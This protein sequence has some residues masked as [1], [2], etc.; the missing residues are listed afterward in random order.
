M[1]KLLSI[2]AA[3]LLTVSLLTVP[4]SAACRGKALAGSLLKQALQNRICG[5]EI[6]NIN[7]S[8]VCPGLDWLFKPN[9]NQH[10]TNQPNVNQP[11]TS[12]PGTNQP[13]TPVQ[14]P[15]VP[16]EGEDGILAFESEVVTL[17]NAARAQYGLSALTINK[18]LCQVARYKSQDMA[19]K[20]YFAH[21]SPTYGSPFQM[22]QSFGISYRT[23]GENIA[24]GQQ[25]P[26]AVVDAWMNSSGHRANI[27]NSSYTQIG[28]GF[29]ANG[30][31]WTQMFIG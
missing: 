23:A 30:Y 31:Y 4:A 25:T 26:Q 12:Q 1:K 5:S 11:G 7:P 6:F 13:D 3:M 19:E 20:G 22:M 21:E 27:L 9:T 29:Y 14:T 28:V 24:Y 8:T 10:N 16:Q 15:D 17:V 2:T 18:D